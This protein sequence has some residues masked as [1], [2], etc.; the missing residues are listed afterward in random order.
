MKL[1]RINWN[2]WKRLK[3]PWSEVERW[4]LDG[5]CVGPGG[6]GD[7]LY[8]TARIIMEY[9]V[10]KPIDRVVIV[11]IFETLESGK[12]WSDHLS[13]VITTTNHKQTDLTKDPWIM[14]YC[15]AVHLGRYD[16]IK[17]YKPPTR[18][19]KAVSKKWRK[20]S[21]FLPWEYAWYNALLGKDR[22]WKIW[23]RLIPYFILPWHTYVLYGFMEVYATKAK[24]YY[25]TKK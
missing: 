14:A 7:I 24:E 15:C 5:W 25:K 11:E 12:R 10:S 6:N 17:L 16:L 2:K 13:P 19:I 4:W 3:Q 1:F 21:F 23:R 22:A 9:L 8:N 18:P 20:W